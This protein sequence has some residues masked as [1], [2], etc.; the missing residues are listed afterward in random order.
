MVAVLLASYGREDQ[1]RA[2]VVD[3]AAAVRREPT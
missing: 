3:L 2:A 1:L